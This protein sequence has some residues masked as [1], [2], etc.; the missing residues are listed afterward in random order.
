M[1]TSKLQ[2]VRLQD[3]KPSAFTVDT[4]NLTFDIQT[5]HTVVTAVSKLSR[6]SHETAAG[7]PLQ[8][9]GEDL[10]LLTVMIDDQTLTPTDYQLSETGLTIPKTPDTFTLTIQTRIYPHKNTVL[11][12]LYQSHNLFCT[13][14]ESHGFRRMTYFLDRP[15]VM[16]C[17]TTTIIA[18]KQK[19]PILL[20]NGNCI[21]QT[22]VE[23]GRH[24]VKWE[25]PF[26]KPC[27]LF[28]LVAGDLEFIEDSFTTCS[29]RDVSLRIYVEPGQKEKCHHAMN[30]LK[31]AMRWDEEVYGREY[32]LDIFMIVAV[33]DFNFGAMENKGLNVF[34]SKYILAD[35]KTATDIDYM[36][37]EGVVAH[38][39]FHNWTGN[40]VTCRDWFQLSLKEGLTVFRD[41]EFSRDRNSRSVNRI[42]DV[43]VLRTFQFT[44]DAGPMAH[45]VRPQSYVEINN[46][47]TSTVYNKGAEVIRMM[48]TLLGAEGFRKGTDLYFERHDGQAVTTDDFVAAMADANDF[49]LTQFKNWYNQAGTP[50]LTLQEVYDADNQQ[51]HVSVTQAT[52][53]TPGQ[54]TKDPFHIPLRLALYKADG[55]SIP[56]HC[57]ELSQKGKEEAILEI[58]HSEQTFTFSKVSERP[59]LSV[60]R[61]F[62]A[63][64]KV[65]F[66]RSNADLLFLMASDNNG[67]AR[68]EAG[69]EL[70]QRV[71]LGLYENSSDIQLQGF[72][73]KLAAA[74]QQLL[75]QK[76]LDPAL[77]AEMLKLPSYD[78]L[79]E[80]VSEVRVKDMVAARQSLRHQLVR[81]LEPTL[82]TLYDTYNPTTDYSIEFAEI[83]KRSLRNQSL[84]YLMYTGD[85]NYCN[86]SFEQF[87]EANN[88]TDQLA[89]LATLS[90]QICS[91]RQQA[92]KSFY[93]QWKSDELVMDKWL[94]IQASSEL[95]ETLQ[96][97]K[98]LA[99]HPVFDIKNP[100]KVR[101]LLGAFGR[102]VINFH[103]EDGQ[104]YELLTDYIIE[105]DQLNP[106]VA[107]RLISPL[108]QWKKFA[109]VHA[110][111]MHAQLERI[112]NREKLSK[113]VAEIVSK[114]LKETKD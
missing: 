2:E 9:D 102:N 56:C 16:A 61:G 5:E 114:S 20:S 82:K 8:L 14:C 97:V 30:S 79:F 80:F 17:Y 58:K 95:P 62:S 33:S 32:D 1:N 49:D 64:I 18:D 52:P 29:G 25:D 63:P 27:Y 15:D 35:P 45:P 43:N 47:Y 108:I 28:A 48:H 83:A 85:E 60:L 37:I 109:S 40:R 89:A 50:C 112:A 71:I 13:Q 75:T 100:N 110:D 78:Y 54:N 36:N 87:T 12:G 21:E 24:S 53:A 73:P 96:E 11:S 6:A 34:N 94:I 103:Q 93:E 92:L 44:E 68:W 98:K 39:Y 76:D 57:Y 55:S 111:K 84:A 91:Q 67:F 74:L 72:I 38:E 7:K 69:Q 42:Q 23:A 113:G 86:T 101:S 88:M 90:H 66:A 70:F 65:N 3:Y 107:S 59:T 104:G 106:Q 46:F 81:H 31:A 105:L 41:Q 77:R 4:V 26:K 19:Y 51:Y 22:D 10:E 99:R